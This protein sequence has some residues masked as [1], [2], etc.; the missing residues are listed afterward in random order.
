MSGLILRDLESQI[1]I[2]FGD[3]QKSGA[4]GFLA[5]FLTVFVYFYPGV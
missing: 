2:S 1:P 5:I 3:S 4:Y